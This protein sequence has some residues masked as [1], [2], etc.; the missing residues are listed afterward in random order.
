MKFS[1][2]HYT[3]WI[4]ILRASK[5]PS[6][7]QSVL[8]ELISVMNN[9]LYQFV[10]W[11]HKLA[12]DLNNDNRIWALRW[13]PYTNTWK[14][15]DPAW[16]L[17]DVHPNFGFGFKWSNQQFDL[18]GDVNNGDNTMHSV[19]AKKVSVI[20]E[21]DFSRINDFVK[22]NTPV[23]EEPTNRYYSNTD[24][25]HWTDLLNLMVP[26]VEFTKAFDL[27]KAIIQ[28]PFTQVIPWKL[29]PRYN[30]NSNVW[31]G[32]QEILLNP[33]PLL[34]AGTDV[35]TDQLAGVAYWWSQDKIKVYGGVQHRKRQVLRLIDPCLI[36]RIAAVKVSPIQQLMGLEPS[37]SSSHLIRMHQVK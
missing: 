23:I 37:L 20:A 17:A 30:M 26:P 7:C 9:P 11:E 33:S 15:F 19:E 16:Y 13:V 31:E 24:R 35:T 25:Q 3:K 6:G 4:E 36:H 10:Y 14:T 28:S 5:M 32:E 21:V 1:P 12:P 2:V 18:Y 34:I 8:D 27:L 22:S 29:P